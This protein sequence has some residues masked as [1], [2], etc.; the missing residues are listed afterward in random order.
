M[1]ETKNAHIVLAGKPEGKRPLA[2]PLCRW[3]DNIKMD[4]K[5]VEWIQL[6]QYR[7]RCQD[8]LN[9]VMYVRLPLKAGNSLTS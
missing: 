5:A 7:D 6:A 1:S 8:L 2:G 9:K 4:L 3:K